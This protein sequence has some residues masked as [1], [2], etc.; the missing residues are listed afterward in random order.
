MKGLDIGD[1]SIFLF[2]ETLE[3]AGT[4]FWNGPLGLFEVPPFDHATNEIAQFLAKSNKITIV[5]GGDTE[6]AIIRIDMSEYGSSH[7]VA[8]M[9]GSPP[10]YIGHEE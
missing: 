5:G 10:G 6:K 8:R 3:R 1:E 4:I 7:S 2:E 9:I